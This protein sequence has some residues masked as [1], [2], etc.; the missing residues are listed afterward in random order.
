MKKPIILVI[1]DHYVF[2]NTKS[3]HIARYYI[4]VWKEETGQNFTVV[5]LTREGPTIYVGKIV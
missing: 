5:E 2:C 3:E 1:T 4:R